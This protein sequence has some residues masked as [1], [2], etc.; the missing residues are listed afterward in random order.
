[1]NVN[2]LLK[3]A[4]W[5]PVLVGI[6]TG[7]VMIW[8][9]CT[10]DAPGMCAMGAAVAFVLVLLGIRNA[11]NIKEE[12]FLPILLFAFGM[13]GILLSI[14]LLLDGEF[15]EAPGLGLIGIAIGIGLCV[16]AIY[17]RKRKS[18]R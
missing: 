9:G 6:I 12:L 15:G 17:L 8:V 5:L 7:A 13:G 18:N 14:V 1:M 2:R 4:V 16:G 3:T 10:N 11:G